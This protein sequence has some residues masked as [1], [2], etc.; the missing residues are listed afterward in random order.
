MAKTLT[1]LKDEWLLIEEKLD[2]AM[3]PGQRD[4]SEECI[5]LE[6]Q[7]SKLAVKI[8]GMGIPEIQK[9]KWPYNFMQCLVKE[10]SWKKPIKK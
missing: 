9:E 3:E 1:Q 8:V 2:E 5:K 10:L 6:I 4:N 7:L